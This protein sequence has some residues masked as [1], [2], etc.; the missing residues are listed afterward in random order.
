M[1]NHN[2]D[3]NEQENRRARYKVWYL[4]LPLFAIVT[5]ML[6]PHSKQHS[7]NSVFQTTIQLGDKSLSHSAAI[8]EQPVTTDQPVSDNIPT[9]PSVVTDA[10][11]GLSFKPLLEETPAFWKT[12]TVKKGDTLYII[13]K[14]LGLRTATATL[15]A[16]SDNSAPLVRLSPGRTLHILS[17]DGSNSDAFIYENSLLT[18][19][20]ASKNG[21]SYDI[22]SNKLPTTTHIA[23]V[24][25]EIISSL[26]TAAKVAGIS[27]TLAM[28]MTE[29]FGWDID[30]AINVQPGDRFKLIFEDVYVNGSKKIHGDILAAEFIN[31]GKT[32]RAIAN[33]DDDGTLRYYSPDGRSMQKTF[34]RTPVKFSRISS[35]FSKARYHPVLK[36]TR[37]HKGVDYAAN[38]GTAVRSTATGRIIHAGRKGGYGNAIII[39]HGSTYSTLY[40]HLSS[41]S[42]GIKKGSKVK[43][44]QIIGRVGSTGLA[45]G[46]HLH[47]EFRI[48]GKHVN[49][50]SF[51]QP[52]SKPIQVSQKA[53]FERSARYWEEELDNIDGLNVA[54]GTGLSGS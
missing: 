40:A 52:A 31:N 15:V 41:F 23:K 2:R 47:Y 27:D 11:S 51:R 43:Q 50:L 3:F 10:S 38:R 24:K 8:S 5:V 46:P 6:L 30:F 44:G 36:R 33:R 54:A 4:L 17:L 53:E 37:A 28:N 25:G 22:S 9:L 26:Y 32:Y 12:I 20:H 48:N 35:R 42:R 45:S 7:E 29:I 13:L 18:W 1:R 19:I 16:R 21:N 49:P 14:R 39:S 34:L